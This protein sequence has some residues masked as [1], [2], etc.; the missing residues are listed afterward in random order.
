MRKTAG[1]LILLNCMFVVAVAIANI[2]GAKVVKI[3]I[4]QVTG[5]VVVYAFSF[6]ATD[7]IGEIWGKEEANAAVRRGIYA[8]I[9]TMLAIMLAINLRPAPYMTEFSEIF[10]KALG[11]NVRMVIAGLC[12]YVCSQYCDVIIFHKFK[13][14]HGD[15]KKYI[16]N[17][18][19][20]IT[21]QLVDTAVFITVAFYGVVPNLFSLIAT[22]Y[23]FKVILALLDTPI[24]Y[25]LT[26]QSKR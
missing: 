23:G 20:T 8:Q 18:A 1:N 14:I 16:R 21:S 10:A 24:F 4:F 11:M 9:F 26:R 2:L 25:Y 22:Q 5:A 13:D 19:S 12:G 6:L 7:V 3:G 17:N 15:S